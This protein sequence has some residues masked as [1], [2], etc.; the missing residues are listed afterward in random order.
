MASLWNWMT[1]GGQKVSEEE[2]KKAKEEEEKSKA[3]GLNLSLHFDKEKYAESDQAR[4]H[5]LLKLGKH[6]ATDVGFKLAKT[7]EY[8]KNDFI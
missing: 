4:I 5:G 7:K 1:G 2:A 3:S 8:E 6:P